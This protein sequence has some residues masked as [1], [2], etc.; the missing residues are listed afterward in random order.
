MKVA[1]LYGHDYSSSLTKFFTG[2]TCYHVGFT[3]GVKFWDMNKIRRRRY[4]AGL[5]VPAQT[6]LV[7][8]PANVTA[9]YLDYKLD[10]D[11]SQYGVVDYMLFGFR[12]LYHLFGQSTRN[13]GGVIC[14]ELVYN[15]MLACGWVPPAEAGFIL[16]GE[17]PSPADLEAIML[18]RLDAIKA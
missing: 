13:A 12:W 14:S 7:D 15:D 4:W 16:L 3:D 10:T 1:F 11:F 9:E 2:S 6:L 8:C 5:Y 18:G 17:V